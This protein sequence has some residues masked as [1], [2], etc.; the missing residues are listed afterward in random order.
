MKS[1][2][3]YLKNII[4]ISFLLSVESYSQFVFTPFENESSFKGAWNLS[5]EIPNYIAA[6]IREFYKVSV[7]S[8]TAFL[9][10]AEK[11]DI[12]IGNPI[13]MQ[14]ASIIVNEAGFSYL[15]LGKINDFGISRFSAG[16]SNIAGYEAYRCDIEISITIFNINSNTTV[17]SHNIKKSITNKGLA[18]NLF[19]AA[20]DDK[21][22]Y[23]ALDKMIFGS[24]E[25]H[26]TIVGEAMFQLCEDLTAEMKQVNKELLYPKKETKA[27]VTM[28][29]SSLEKVKLMT[30]IIRGQIL[31]Y[32]SA[33]GE[34]FINLGSLHGLSK[35]TILNIYAPA[36]SLFDPNSKEFVGISDKNISTLEVVEVR[37]EKFSLAVVTEDK[38]KVQ[39]GMEV[40][41]LLLRKKSD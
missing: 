4:C 14:S 9:S 3:K 2:K 35:G 31:T 19:G 7:L 33:S 8:S 25:F 10:L 38:E 22:Q 5:I 39:K 23:L 28:Q 16:E 1:L 24:E 13:D 30:E 6:Y 26:K 12:S 27:S 21:K 36:D 40:R 18:F 32:D 20:S 11:Q 37:G 29:D 17:F 41:K 15:V 34:A